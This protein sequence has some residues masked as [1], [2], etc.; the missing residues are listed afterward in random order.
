MRLKQLDSLDKSFDLFFEVDFKVGKDLSLL[1][2]EGVKFELLL[3]D[4][5]W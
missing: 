2:Y 1:V 3:G 4:E 5:S